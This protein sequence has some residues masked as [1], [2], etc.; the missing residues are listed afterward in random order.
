MIQHTLILLLVS[1]LVY[2]QGVK[3][4]KNSCN[5]SVIVVSD[6]ADVIEQSGRKAKVYVP[7]KVTVSNDVFD[8][9]DQI[10]VDSLDGNKIIFSGPTG[11]KTAKLQNHRF[12]NIKA[13]RGVWKTSLQDRTSQLWVKLTHFSLFPAGTYSAR[14]KVAVVSNNKII[15]E[16]FVSL[17]YVAQPTI[18]IALDS[19]SQNKVA[20]SNGD[21]QIDLGELVSNTRFDWGINVF[22]NTAY[23]IVLD[24]E[25]NGLRHDTNTQALIGYTIS[26]DNVKIPSSQQLIRRYDFSSGLNN[27]W[28]GFS[29]ELDK[30]ELMPAGNYQDN[31]SFTVYPR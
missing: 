26:F 29:F 11:D 18:S 7:I 12:K 20:G 28:F 8:C 4:A 15:E 9:A 16:Q 3:A 19:S 23:D 10:W 22:S 21:Y 25:Y 6:P 13:K 31:L 24:S 1:L 2:S 30:V 5:G 17:Q 14:V 27:S